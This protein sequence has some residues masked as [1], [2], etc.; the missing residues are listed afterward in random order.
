MRTP[1][2]A[3][4]R[5]YGRRAH[6]PRRHAGKLCVLWLLAAAALLLTSCAPRTSE[7]QVIATP[8][9]LSAAAVNRSAGQISVRPTETPLPVVKA[10]PTPT[11]S[12]EPTST[13]AP[14]LVAKTVAAPTSTPVPTSTSTP[15]ASGEKIVTVGSEMVDCS[16]AE[17][18]SGSG[19]PRGQCYLVKEK[20]QSEWTVFRGTIQGFQFWPGAE[21][22]MV[23]RED[24]IADAPQGG[25]G[26]VWT[27]VKGLYK[28]NVPRTV[29]GS[30]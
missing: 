8:E 18:A 19:A 30:P 1:D 2:Q 22:V 7:R 26:V 23:V 17:A 20:G 9:P 13:A 4:A 16:A 12:P 11:P 5:I 24:R 21:Y 10:G 29:T 27:V 28:N 15:L 3:K 6:L 14:P 25:P